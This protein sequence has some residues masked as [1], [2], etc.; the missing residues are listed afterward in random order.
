M[1]YLLTL[2]YGVCGDKANACGPT[3]DIGAGLKEPGGHII[4]RTSPSDTD[5]AGHLSALSRRLVTLSDERRISQYIRTSC[6][7]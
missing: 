6:G 1:C 3:F 5:N 2:G 4:E 7:R